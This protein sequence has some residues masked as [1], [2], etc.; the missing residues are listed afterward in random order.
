MTTTV[1]YNNDK[2]VDKALDKISKLIWLFVLLIIFG[3]IGFFVARKLEDPSIADSKF[4]DWLEM[5]K[6]FAEPTR[7]LFINLN[8]VSPEN[9]F[10]TTSFTMYCIASSVGGYYVATRILG[11]GLI[12]GI[13]KL[14]FC[15]LI[16][17]VIMPF[18]IIGA[19][20][21]LIKNSIIL[22]INR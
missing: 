4:W 6:A 13:L 11:I 1:H 7:E 14:V 9:T 2:T 3:I 10:F 8:L 22:A 21:S 15:P 19:F 20:I 18:V 16:S 17:P 12:R 5:L